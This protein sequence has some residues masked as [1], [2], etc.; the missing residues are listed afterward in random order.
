[1]GGGGGVIMK[2]FL[3]SPILFL[4]IFSGIFKDFP[5]REE[6]VRKRIVNSAPFKP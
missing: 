1:M 5:K 2:G 6:I 3:K 4:Y